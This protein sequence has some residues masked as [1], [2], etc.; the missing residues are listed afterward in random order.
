MSTRPE[1]ETV[2]SQ[3]FQWR[4]YQLN[5]IWYTDGDFAGVD[6][7]C[8][9]LGTTNRD[10]AEA[11][12]KELDRRKAIELGTTH[13]FQLDPAG[14]L[15]IE[16]GWQ[17]YLASCQRPEG[18]GCVRQRTLSRYCRSSERHRTY[19]AANGIEYWDDFGQA[20]FEEYGL[21][22]S[23]RIS[24]RTRYFELTN[25]RSALKRLIYEKQISDEAGCWLQ[26]PGYPL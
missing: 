17:L 2:N 6:L 25:V 23:P 12:L 8:H 19:C 5:D 16:R 21:N 10:E 22:L 3:Y 1:Y 13:G 15:S 14:R 18:A 11:E 20:E 24:P 4:L 26:L 9:S 7:G